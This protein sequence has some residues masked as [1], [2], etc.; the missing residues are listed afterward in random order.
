KKLFAGRV[1]AHPELVSS[2]LFSSLLNSSHLSAILYYP[3]PGRQL[4][5]LRPEACVGDQ[6]DDGAA[7]PHPVRVGERRAGRRRRAAP[8][9]GATPLLQAPD[10]QVKRR[11]TAA[12]A[13]SLAPA[14]PSAPGQPRRR[15]DARRRRQAKAPLGDSHGPAT[16][17]SPPPRRMPA[18][19]S[20]Q[21]SPAAAPAAQSVPA[22]CTTAARQPKAK[23]ARRASDGPSRSAQL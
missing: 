10:A 5:N 14:G 1:Q 2:R 6:V 7:F 8:A 18:R 12:V 17:P 11:L 22:P 16:S 21:A 15:S 9:D 13:E 3:P 23:A 20:P 4:K 19:R